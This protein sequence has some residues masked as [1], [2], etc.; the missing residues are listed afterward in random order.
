MVLERTT[1]H[2]KCKVVLL[3]LKQYQVVGQLTEMWVVPDQTHL[4]F[5]RVVVVVV[6]AQRALVQQRIEH[7]EKGGMEL[8]LLFLGLTKPMVEAG[9][10]QSAQLAVILK[11]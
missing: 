8:L 1:T 11:V 6:L 4:A 3:Q 2:R 10:E 5:K 9:V 7:L